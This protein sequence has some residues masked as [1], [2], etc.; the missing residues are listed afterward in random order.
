MGVDKALLRLG[1]APL[2]VVVVDRLRQVCPRV[3]VAVDQ[4]GRYDDLGLGVEFAVDQAPGLGPLAGLQ[5]GLRAARTGHALVVACDLPFLNV[6]LLWYMAS[7]PRT[8]EA[9]VP[10]VRGR[11]HPLHAVYS[12]SCL[13]MVDALVAQ[14][15]ASMLHL[16]AS[17]RVQALREGELRRWDPEL[18]SLKNLNRWAD[19][20]RARSI[21]GAPARGEGGLASPRAG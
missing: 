5:T 14:G 17:L 6:G 20:T 18:L 16:L 11:W 4:P 13:D 1:E 19:V 9:L 3:V 12:R 8:Y 2:L 7:L 15:G 10:R 21:M